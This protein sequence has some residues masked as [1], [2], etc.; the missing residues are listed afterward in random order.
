MKLDS[1][2][3]RDSDPNQRLWKALGYGGKEGETRNWRYWP[4]SGKGPWTIMAPFEAAE[5][6][7]EGSKVF[8]RGE[9]LLEASTQWEATRRAMAHFY[10]DVWPTLLGL[11]PLNEDK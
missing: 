11:I 7:Q 9:M 1:V 10:T 3:S 5:Y 4:Q 6:R 8:Y 2:Y